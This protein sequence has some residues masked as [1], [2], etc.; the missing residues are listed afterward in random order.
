MITGTTEKDA[1]FPVLV[2]N[3]IPSRVTLKLVHVRVKQAGEA[4]IVIM[5]RMFM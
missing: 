3:R 2:Y 4:L 1:K 5:V